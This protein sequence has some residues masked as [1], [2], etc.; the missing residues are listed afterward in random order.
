MKRLTLIFLLISTFSFGQTTTDTLWGSKKFRAGITLQAGAAFWSQPNLNQILI[1]NNRPTTKQL[2]IL[3]GIG[4]VF[5]WDKYRATFLVLLSRNKN[6]ANGENLEQRFGGGE[7]NV[8]YAIIRKKG[9]SLSPQIG[10]GAID[11]VLKIR[12][13]ATP[14]PIGNIFTNRNTTELFNRQG[15]VNAALNFG[16]AYAPKIRAHLFQLTTGYRFGFLNTNWSSDPNTEVLTNSST[17]HLRQFYLSFKMNF[18][19]SNRR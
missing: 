7:L 8:E 2:N 17:D 16:F 5:Q 6:S 3:S 12:K 11:G 9:F 18:M 15:F 10:G 13:Y 4:N 1:Q 19:Y 14:Q